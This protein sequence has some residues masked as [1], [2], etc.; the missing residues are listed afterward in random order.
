MSTSTTQFIFVWL[1][2]D[3][4]PIS[5]KQAW[6]WHIKWLLHHQQNHTEVN[7]AYLASMLLE[8]YSPAAL[9]TLPLHPSTKSAVYL[10]HA[11]QK[12]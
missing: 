4:K 3:S 1:I 12:C 11:P 10:I 8:L 5:K 2:Q 9:G 6:Y 7:L